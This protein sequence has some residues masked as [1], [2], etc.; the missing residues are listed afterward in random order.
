MCVTA[1]YGPP[2]VARSPFF[3]SA[4]ARRITLRTFLNRL[5]NES[6]E[7][8]STTCVATTRK[9]ENKKNDKN[10]CKSMPMFANF[11]AYAV[12][13]SECF[14]DVVPFPLFLASSGGIRLFIHDA[15][16]TM[17]QDKVAG[18]FHLVLRP[19][20]RSNTFT[21]CRFFVFLV[22]LYFAF[23]VVG[24]GRS[25]SATCRNTNLEKQL[26]LAG[27]IG[28]KLLRGRKHVLSRSHLECKLQPFF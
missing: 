10:K 26:N 24:F 13:A 5:R 23:F 25:F 16:S 27:S 12:I 4:T 6:S 3:S 19:V 18:Q 17:L 20:Q 8:S 28:C 9:P 21:L 22:F 2:P 15:G 14:G 11:C 7:R 1:L